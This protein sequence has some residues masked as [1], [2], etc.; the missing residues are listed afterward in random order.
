M[1]EQAKDDKPF[2]SR[3]SERKRAVQAEE[4][5]Q[6]S[7]P[8]PDEHAEG[9]AAE[10]RAEHDANRAAAEAIDLETLNDASDYAPFF[11][12]GVPAALKHA[13]LRKLWRSNPVFAVL[14]GLN[15]YDLDYTWPKSG[16]EV[17]KTAWKVGRGF[18]SGDDESAAEGAGKPAED[19]VAVRAPTEPKESAGEADAE[20]PPAAAEAGSPETAAETAESPQSETEPELEADE[21]EPVK[22]S[23]SRR[24]D[25][26][27]FAKESGGR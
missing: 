8:A 24:L 22:V 12:A 19:P 27:A 26:A 11:K 14:D 21:P 25:F 17:V 1:A 9:R 4:G 7:T 20:A 23:L 15:D 3:W 18:L 2:L 6:E 16:S 5:A 10:E 13:A